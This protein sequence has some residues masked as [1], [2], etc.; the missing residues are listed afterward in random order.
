[1]IRRPPKSPRT[2]T[3]FPYTTIFRSPRRGRDPARTSAVVGI[4][5]HSQFP[6]GG[7]GRRPA[8]QQP[9]VAVRRGAHGNRCPCVGGIAGRGTAEQE[10][11]GCRSEEH[12]SELQSLM[13]ILY[14]VF[15]LKRQK[16]SG[17]RA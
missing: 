2:N 9:R 12:T 7:G 4:G 14:A 11:C 16:P 8:D 1:M 6:G 13:R 10:A 5:A 3:L 15:C 17:M